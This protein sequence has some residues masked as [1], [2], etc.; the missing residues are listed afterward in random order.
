MD[1]TRM[2]SYCLYILLGASTYLI[3]VFLSPKIT[4]SEQF[5]CVLL[6]QTFQQ[7]L[8]L[9]AIDELHVL[10]QWGTTWRPT[11]SH[12]RILRS[13][14]N[15]TVPWFGTSATLD[16]D[17]LREVKTLAEFDETTYVLKTSI[18]CPKIQLTVKPL[19]YPTNSSC[20]LKFVV[21]PAQTYPQA[22]NLRDPL[23]RVLDHT[24]IDQTE[25]QCLIHANDL[26]GT[27]ALLD[28]HKNESLIAETI[29]RIEQ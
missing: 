20:D 2:V 18:D 4:L 9:I 26:T 13:H 16:P 22:S 27:C 5:R 8:V 6:D 19:E 24:L 1:Y 15:N 10:E 14:I 3:I 11:Y 25:L 7:C 21:N 17:T 28:Q 29:C 23:I 12:L